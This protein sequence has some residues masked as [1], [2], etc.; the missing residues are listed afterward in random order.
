M[1]YVEIFVGEIRAQ[2]HDLESSSL[3]A[4]FLLSNLWTGTGAG[5]GT[6]IP[7]P[8]AFLIRSLVLILVAPPPESL[9]V[10]I[11][12]KPTLDVFVNGLG[13]ALIKRFRVCLLIYMKGFVVVVEVPSA[14]VLVIRSELPLSKRLI[15]KCQCYVVLG[16]RFGS[17]IFFDKVIK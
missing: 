3:L 8:S 15:N 6:R 9:R 11:P 5:A 4:G 10:F 14:I 17:P 2:S 16:D 7:L 13:F 12:I 1:L